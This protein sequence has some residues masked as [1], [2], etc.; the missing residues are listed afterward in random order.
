MNDELPCFSHESW[1]CIG[2]LY[3]YV[4]SKLQHF[5]TYCIYPICMFLLIHLFHKHLTTFAYKIKF[6]ILF[7]RLSSQKSFL[8][9]EKMN[10]T[11]KMNALSWPTSIQ[12]EKHVLQFSNGFPT[13]NKSLLL[14]KRCVLFFKQNTFSFQKY[15][16]KF[17]CFFFE[18]YFSHFSWIYF[19]ISLK[20]LAVHILKSLEVFRIQL[21]G[22]NTFDL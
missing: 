7:L 21:H 6:I 17:F 3:A 1:N 20:L 19:E 14:P 18:K 5:T 11:A 16:S 9:W 22:G 4:V 15:F 2:L 10:P 8:N 12:M 13:L